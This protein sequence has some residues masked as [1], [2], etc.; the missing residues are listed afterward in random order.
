M[1]CPKCGTENPDDGKFCRK[2][3][4]DLKIVADALTG[5]L[6]S[7]DEGT[8]KKKKKKPTWE[9]ALTLIFVSLAFFTIS[10]VLAF[11]PIGQFW[12]FWIL[13]P[14]FATLAGGVGQYIEL[15]QNQQS[16]VNFGSDEKVSFP[17][18]EKVSALPPK[19]TDF[20]SNIPDVK[21]KTGDLAPPSVVERTTRHLEMDSEGKTMTLPKNDE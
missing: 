6:I 19:Q 11:N 17:K 21:H 20:V 2:C 3:G 15:K 7:P 18:S 8:G 1:F 10:I 9:S 14:A 12:W 5:K 13:I 16:N 4:S